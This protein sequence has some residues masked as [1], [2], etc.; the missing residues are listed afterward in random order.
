M[1]TYLFD[2]FNRYKRFSEELDAKTILCNKAWWV[3]NDSGEKEVYIFNTDGTLIISVSGR[4][5]NATWRY[6]SA[7]KS[8]II[9]GNNQSY[10][11]HPAFYDKTIFALQ[12]DG[13]DNYAFLIDENNLPATPMKSL[14]DLKSHFAEK[15]RQEELI[16]QRKQQVELEILKKK[17]LEAE[18]KRQEIIEEQQRR[19]IEEN[20]QRQ[21]IAEEKKR[22]ELRKQEEALNDRV[23]EK[24][25]YILLPLGIIEYI[26]E[27]LSSIRSV[28]YIPIM[29]TAGSMIFGL[30]TGNSLMAGLGAI[31]FACCIVLC[32]ISKVASLCLDNF[33]LYDITFYKLK[34][35]YKIARY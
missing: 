25:V 21:R 10:M 14:S 32:I 6:I 12:I 35:K 13:R 18:R 1:K 30:Y 8:L 28:I 4:V 34:K 29:F 16:E 22:E 2:T 5:T 3:F 17:E 26:L 27:K 19:E 15:E 31:L 20:K 33:N 23:Y 9:S 11:V 7:N 24:Y